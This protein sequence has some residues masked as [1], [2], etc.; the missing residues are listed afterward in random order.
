[1][2]NVTVAT[3]A[4]RVSKLAVQ[5]AKA[6]IVKAAKAK[7]VKA[8]ARIAAAQNVNL[9][10]LAAGL[11]S[12]LFVYRTDAVTSRKRGEGATANYA[13]ALIRE[14]GANFWLVSGQKGKLS[15]NEAELRRAVRVEQNACK[16]LAESRGL[17]NV[18][19]PW[20]DAL[21]LCKNPEG[22]KKA[23]AKAKPVPERINIAIREAFRIAHENFETY[24]RD[25]QYVAAYDALAALIKS[26]R[27]DI[28][29]ITDNQ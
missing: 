18:Y 23:A 15:E 19:K 25:E 1:M 11:K 28:K 12:P 22:K 9:V 6:K 17:R 8:K 7:A 24:E 27:I 13:A 10:A 4:P 5:M 21:A 14:Y 2:Q 16:A 3:K 20:S 29:S 26:R